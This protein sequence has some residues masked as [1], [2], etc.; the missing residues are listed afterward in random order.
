MKARRP[1]AAVSAVGSGSAFGSAGAIEATGIRAGYGGS[2]VVDDVSISIPT[3]KCTALVGP[4]GCGK[5]TLLRV[6]AG[7][8]PPSAG[9]VTVDGI[10]IR[11]LRTREIAKRVAMLSQ[12]PAVPDGLTVRQLVEQGRYPHAGPLRM[13]RRQ[14][15][16]SIDAA[17]RAVDIEHFGDRYLDELSGG[18][19]QRAWIALALAQ[20]SPIL[21]LDEPTT[22]LDLGHQMETLELVDAIR[23]EHGLTVLVVLHDLNHAIAVAQHIVV[24]ESGRIV[25]QGDPVDV[26]TVA[27][28]RDVFRID[29]HI[30]TH[31]TSGNPYVI[32]V[33]PARNDR[34]APAAVAPMTTAATA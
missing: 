7:M 5:S 17:M 16:P 11:R 10:P 30:T 15:D 20:Q 21:L 22:F 3:G 24:V 27:L 26:I 12:S 18:E 31:P 25:A 28:L 2:L 4:N 19:R 14:D 32:P 1:V 29:A 23:V 13:L 34:N 33:G 9:T 6:L 8:L